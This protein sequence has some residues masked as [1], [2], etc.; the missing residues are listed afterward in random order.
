[1]EDFPSTPG[2]NSVEMA[3]FLFAPALLRF[4]KAALTVSGPTGQWTSLALSQ[5]GSIMLASEWSLG[6]VADGH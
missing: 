3:K 1:M 5:D 4:G 2:E 6:R